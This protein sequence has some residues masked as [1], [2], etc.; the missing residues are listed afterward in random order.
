MAG[1]EFAK[2]RVPVWRRFR[3]R[4]YCNWSGKPC[5]HPGL[6]PGRRKSPLG[7]GLQVRNLKMVPL[8]PLVSAIEGKHRMIAVEG[9]PHRESAQESKNI[10]ALGQRAHVSHGNQSVKPATQ[11]CAARPE[12]KFSPAVAS[13]T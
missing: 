4:R 3:R 5:R 9:R 2:A 10:V 6:R 12:R 13:R 11:K 1:L 8:N 7:N